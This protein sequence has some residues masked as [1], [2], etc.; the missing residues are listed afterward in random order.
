MDTEI[1][2]RLRADPF[3]PFTVVM[4]SGERYPVHDPIVA[5]MGGTLLHIARP[6]ADGF[7]VLNMR[8]IASVEVLEPAA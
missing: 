2:D 8:Q 6:D 3:V 7:D 5:A 1:K 4:P